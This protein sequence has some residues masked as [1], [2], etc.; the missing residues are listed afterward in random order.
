MLD[1]KKLETIVGV[2]GTMF[3][4]VL[5]ISVPR[6]DI[7]VTVDEFEIIPFMGLTTWV[8]FRKGPHQVTMMGD[9]VLLPDEITVAMSPF[10]EAGLYATA[11]HNHFIRE[12]PQV[13]FM[14]VEGTAD[15]E[16]LAQP[17][18]KTLDAI[19]AVR[20]ANPVPAAKKE[21]AGNLDTAQ[22]ENVIGT[23]GE[24]KDGVFKVVL[25]RPDVPVK[26][27]RCGDLDINSAM[28]Y[29][30]WA[31]FQGTNERAAVC[32]DFAMLESEVTPVISALHAG[33]IEVVAIHNHMFF[34]QP[35]VVF[36]HYWG[37][38]NAETLA[39]TFKSALG[40]QQKQQAAAG[41]G[42]S[43]CSS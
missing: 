17:I 26:C 32:G 1:Q 31:A 12:K 5:K 43:C 42:E 30:T 19:K 13:M 15:E 24:L 29:N 23:K 9:L 22:L 18:R 27:S 8:A 16:T 20:Q 40:Q 37:I 41:A 35:R 3:D 4:D 28:G 25:G 36:L 38:G 7:R 34:E 10:I 21:V 11:L 14:H 33:G 39:T 2:K 6:K